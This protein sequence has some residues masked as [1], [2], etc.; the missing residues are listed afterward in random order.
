MAARRKQQRKRDEKRAA[1]E[2]QDVFD[3]EQG[4]YQPPPRSRCEERPLHFRGWRHDTARAKALTWRQGGRLVD[5]QITIDLLESQQWRTA[6][7][8]DCQHGHVHFHVTES[9]SP[10]GKGTHLYTLNSV[11]DMPAGLKQ[12]IALVDRFIADHIEQSE[13][14]EWTS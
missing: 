6:L 7:E 9:D 2:R 10:R 3:N 4:Q 11:G 1:R 12:A 8:V 13:Q 14:E 5:F